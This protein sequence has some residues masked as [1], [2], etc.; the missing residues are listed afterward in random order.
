VNGMNGNGANGN[1]NGHGNGLGWRKWLPWS[2]LEASE[3]KLAPY[4]R[5]A[6]QL[7]YDLMGPDNPRSV[8]LV[9]PSASGLCSHSS[10]ALARSL[11]EDFR[12]S[13]LLVDACPL[14]A[15]T[16]RLLECNGHPGFMDMVTQPSLSLHDLVLPTNDA[17][18]SFLAAGGHC[19]RL[20]PACPDL[21]SSLLKTIESR[22]DF[23]VLAGGSV[24]DNPA[25]LAMAPHVGCVLLLAVEDETTLDDFDAARVALD[26]CRPRKFG[27]VFTQPV[28]SRSILPGLQRK[29]AAA[30]RPT[31][32]EA[33]MAGGTGSS[34]SSSP[35]SQDETDDGAAAVRLISAINSVLTVDS[36][37][38]SK[39]VKAAGDPNAVLAESEAPA[40]SRSIAVSAGQGRAA[41]SIVASL[42]VCAVLG[43]ISLG[44]RYWL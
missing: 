30:V 1:G 33:S 10:S 28:R 22:Y 44:I 12:Q 17:R 29:S 16:S 27:V 13:V 43:A 2:K 20:Q 34:R 24:L 31:N 18:V 9:T 26:V 8:M 37:H 3:E 4:R 39:P 36:S 40:D 23:T 32:S 19:D 7:H 42:L 21:L 11:G 14:G 38:A 25:A 35:V 6:L 5:L 15:E 41:G